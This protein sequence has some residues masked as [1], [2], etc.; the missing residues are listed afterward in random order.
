MKRGLFSALGLLAGAANLGAVRADLDDDRRA[1]KVKDFEWRRSMTLFVSGFPHETTEAQLRALFGQYGPL[2]SVR[3]AKVRETGQG[4][5]FAFVEIEEASGDLA[6]VELNKSR[7]N[8][9]QLNVREATPEPPNSKAK[10]AHVW[11]PDY[12]DGCEYGDAEWE[13][14]AHEARR[15]LVVLLAILLLF[16]L[17]AFAAYGLLHR[18]DA[19]RGVPTLGDGFALLVPAKR[20]AR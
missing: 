17:C 7:W 3:V 12:R 9:K 1:K 5:G 16:L 2:A 8:G 13:M 18:A 6:I 14:T 4:R 19:Q 15:L 11:T 10:A 20:S